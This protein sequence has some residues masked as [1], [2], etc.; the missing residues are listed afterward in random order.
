V[1]EVAGTQIV[2]G[3]RPSLSPV[4]ELAMNLATGCV[5]DGYLKVLIVGKA[6]IEKVPREGAAMCNRVGI[7]LE[8]DSSPISE[9]NTVDHIEE[10]FL[11]RRQP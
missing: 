11:H 1:E 9:R 2:P 5:D 10:K 6:F 4:N 3:E 7:R 8:F